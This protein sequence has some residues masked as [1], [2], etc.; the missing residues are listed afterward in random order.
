MAPE[1]AL[2]FLIRQG[3]VLSPPAKKSVSEGTGIIIIGF[4]DVLILRSK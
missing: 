3:R 2:K 4:S 1:P